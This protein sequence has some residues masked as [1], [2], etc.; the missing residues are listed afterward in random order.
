[1]KAVIILYAALIFAS[2]MLRLD[3]DPHILINA[4]VAICFTL[5]FMFLCLLIMQLCG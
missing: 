4:A 1:M 3:D 2:W 5:A